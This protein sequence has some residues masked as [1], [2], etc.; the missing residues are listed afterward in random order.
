[1]ADIG[2]NRA[3]VG[4]A[5]V[6]GGALVAFGPYSLFRICGGASHHTMADGAVMEGMAHSAETGASMICKYSAAAEL[7]IGIVIA[8][9]GI[10]YLLFSNP[11]A[12][13]GLSFGI[14]LSSVLALLVITVLIGV[15]PKPMTCATTTQPAIILI[16]TLLTA[17]T[18][19]NVVYLTRKI[20]INVK[21]A[22]A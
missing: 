14:G 4:A 13:L 21:V 15:D 11:Y 3:I 16:S 22:H 8:L 19:V 17:F 12:H 6:L 2:K 1:M 7:G 18:L 9:L 10:A 20:K 5:A